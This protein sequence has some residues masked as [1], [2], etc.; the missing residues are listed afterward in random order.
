M[1]KKDGTGP[2][3]QG[4]KTG[5]G[6]G[7]CCSEYDWNNCCGMTRGKKTP[8]REERKEMLKR[9]ADLLKDDLGAVEKELSDLK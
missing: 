8:N 5:R 6:M 4:P 3:G 1:P 2:T 7:C 9:K